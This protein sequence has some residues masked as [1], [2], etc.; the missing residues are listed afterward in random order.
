MPTGLARTIILAVLIVHGL[1]HGGVIAALV[2]I[3]ARPGTDSGGWR[4]ARSW[5]MPSLAPKTSMALAIALYAIS[6][7]GFLA[8]ALAFQGILISGSAWSGLAVGSAVVSTLAILLFWGT[9]PVFNTTA[10]LAVNL[11]VFITQLW[12]KWPAG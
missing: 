9:W 4:R 7:V 12:L 6:M 5:L 8:V 2:W 10:A 3:E 11:A 1:G